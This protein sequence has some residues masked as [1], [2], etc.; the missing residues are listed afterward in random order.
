MNPSR[1]VSI[2]SRSGASRTIGS[3]TVPWAVAAV[4][5]G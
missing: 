4:I 3:R 5:S 2:P 1:E